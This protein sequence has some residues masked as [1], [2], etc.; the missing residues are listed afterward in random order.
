M[1]SNSILDYITNYLNYSIYILDKSIYELDYL[2]KRVEILQRKMKSRFV[3]KLQFL[4]Y[5]VKFV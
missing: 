3:F 5:S 1:R 2:E 4:S